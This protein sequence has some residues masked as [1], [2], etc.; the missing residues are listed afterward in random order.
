MANFTPG[1]WV[2]G[3]GLREHVIPYPHKEGVVY[4][5]K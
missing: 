2:I 3:S 5:N 4:R 1:P